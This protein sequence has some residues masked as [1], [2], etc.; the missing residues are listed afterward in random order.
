MNLLV[1]S[2][3]PGCGRRGLRWSSSPP[4]KD[5]ALH[6]SRIG[7]EGEAD[8]RDLSPLYLLVHRRVASLSLTPHGESSNSRRRVQGVSGPRLGVAAK[9]SLGSHRAQRGRR[10]PRV[11]QL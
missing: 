4:H 5:W 3:S 8:P 1:V 11:Q 10:L 9:C 7:S 6:P 2:D